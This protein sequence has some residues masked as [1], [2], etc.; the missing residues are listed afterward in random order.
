MPL[1]AM[2]GIAAL[3]AAIVP[4]AAWGYY[5]VR[6]ER[7]VP[8]DLGAPHTNAAP[9]GE[10]GRR[11]PLTVLIDLCGRR[12]APLVL[13]LMGPARVAGVRRR[14]NAAGR[15]GGMTADIYATRVAGSVIVFGAVGA[16][17]MLQAS[18]VFGLL[19]IATGV[20]WPDLSLRALARNR[21]YEIERTL[22]D[23]LDVLSVTVSAGL[24]F[25]HA[26]SR[27]AESMRG[28]LSEE[29]RVA[30]RQMELGTTRREA[31]EEM[32]TRNSAESLSQFVTAIL[33]AEELGAPLTQA[34]LEISADMRRESAQAAR[35][36]AARTAPR[37]TLIVTLVMVPG[38]LIL[39]AGALYVA[40]GGTEGIGG[41]LG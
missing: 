11:G 26:L 25:R 38:V 1:L 27:V 39:L 14:I 10:R 9:R 17:V 4:L 31:F 3:A 2:F 18:L 33:Q 36:R 41:V 12:F 13:K 15:P 34:L 22:P 35:R 40:Q 29:F 7:P 32:R 16:L 20:L 21:Q 23:F 6:Y 8:A 24:G 28:P 30:L 19:L 37:V 5:L